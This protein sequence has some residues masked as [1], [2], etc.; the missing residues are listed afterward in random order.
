ML[1]HKK[2]IYIYI[3]LLKTTEYFK[4]DKVNFPIKRLDVI[5]INNAFLVVVNCL[6]IDR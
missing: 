6:V 3:Y 1:K 4:T 5:N 2:K